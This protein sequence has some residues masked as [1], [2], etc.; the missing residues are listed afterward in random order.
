MTP[1]DKY[2]DAL[3]DPQRLAL[4][5]LRAT[6]LDAVPE[7][8]EQFS[9]GMPAFRYRGAALVWMGAT[10]KHCALYGVSEAGLEADLAGYDT[11]GRG[12]VRFQPDAPLPPA[13]VRTLLQARIA[14][15]EGR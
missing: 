11:S 4:H 14:Q 10:A 3:P 9:Y 2:L 13:L 12:T 5:Q 15:I 6:V 8:E 1:T 7:A